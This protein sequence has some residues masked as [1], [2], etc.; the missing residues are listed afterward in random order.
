MASD[1]S[2]SYWADP[3]VAPQWKAARDKLM[4]GKPLAPPSYT[5]VIVASKDDALIL[6]KVAGLVETP[7]LERTQILSP[8]K[9]KTD[10]TVCICSISDEAILRL[11]G[12]INESSER[13][14]RFDG[15]PRYAGRFLPFAKVRTARRPLLCG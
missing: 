4:A 7:L 3:T 11:D 1:K 5:P 14:V 10:E 12:W 8:D 2:S 15:K 13:L 6:E 9:A